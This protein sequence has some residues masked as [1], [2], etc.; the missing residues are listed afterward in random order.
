MNW[1]DDLNE[2][3]TSNNMYRVEYLNNMLNEYCKEYILHL[4]EFNG[5]IAKFKT[6][7]SYEVPD[8][9]AG[10][11]LGKLEI[12]FKSNELHVTFVM[13]CYFDK[14][15]KLRFIYPSDYNYAAEFKDIFEK[16]S[17]EKKDFHIYESDEFNEA[18]K[19]QKEYIFQLFNERFKQYIEKQKSNK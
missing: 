17:D 19:I 5:I 18:E 11:K 2:Y 14:Y 8:L 6:E 10:V 4:N 1:K 15:G 13:T 16:T 3:F 9:P 7:V 12:N